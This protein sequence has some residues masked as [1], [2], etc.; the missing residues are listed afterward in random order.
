M[1]FLKRLSEL[2]GRYGCENIVYFDESGF[3]SHTYRKHGWTRRGAKIFA[4]V[5][6]K[7][8]KRTNLIMAWRSG[9]W[10]APEAFTGSCDAD[11]VNTWLKDKLLP[12]LTKPGVI[13]FDNARFHK[14]KDI[15]KLYKKHGHRI[16]PLSP[17][18]PDF[19]PIENSFGTI[20][21]I[22]QFKPPDTPIID[23]IKMS[24]PY[25]E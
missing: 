15:A 17:Y 21:N 12:L 1:C 11:R 10:L 9:R 18:S 6:G 4:D 25:L 2:S 22:R 14:K 24:N 5:P 19:N 16:L 23:I 7:R 13:V 8:G 20:K 3:A